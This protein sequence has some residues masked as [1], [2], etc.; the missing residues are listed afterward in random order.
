MIWIIIKSGYPLSTKFERL[1]QERKISVNTLV[2]EGPF[3]W[4]EKHHHLGLDP[5]SRELQKFVESTFGF[6]LANQVVQEPF[7]VGV[8]W[9]RV[10]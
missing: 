4:L 6:R 2:G 8:A 9:V 10:V 7:S 3:C 1:S 5:N